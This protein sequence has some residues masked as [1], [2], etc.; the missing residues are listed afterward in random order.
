VCV[1][2]I[3]EDMSG[4]FPNPQ[5]SAAKTR[6]NQ[7]IFPPESEKYVVLTESSDSNVAEMNSMN[8][9]EQGQNRKYK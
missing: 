5:I 9:K 6:W 7:R 8:E 1:F 4:K 2:F 3:F